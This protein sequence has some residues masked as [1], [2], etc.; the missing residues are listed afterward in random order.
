MPV[1]LRSNSGEAEFK[2]ERGGP[3]EYG[4]EPGF[5]SSIQLRGEHSDGDHTFPF[6]TSIEGLWLR[7]TDLGELRDHITRWIRQP[8]SL[9][10]VDDLNGEFELARLPH[11]RV[12]VRF[13]P[14]PGKVSNWNPVVF[15]IYSAGELRGEFHFETDQS[16]LTL[17]AQELSAEL[18]R[19]YVG[20]K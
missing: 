15:I 6:S 14:H 20:S 12:C 19:G 10:N 2:I 16:C 1:I 3:S 9:L 18:S 7:A 4:H 17:F 11:Q 5:E 8:L 13:G